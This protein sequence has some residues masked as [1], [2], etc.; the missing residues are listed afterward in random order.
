[1]CTLTLLLSYR[2]TGGL[3]EAVMVVVVIA[4]QVEEPMD[5]AAGW[6]VGWQKP[7]L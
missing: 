7:G 1:M 4:L 3:K 2:R 6:L 5:W